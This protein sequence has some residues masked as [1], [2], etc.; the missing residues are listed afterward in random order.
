VA[1]PRTD[2]FVLVTAALFRAA[3]PQ[4]AASVHGDRRRTVRLAGLRGCRAWRC[5]AAAHGACLSCHAGHRTPRR[6]SALAIAGADAVLAAWLRH[7]FTQLLPFDLC[8]ARFA[9]AALGGPDV[10]VATTVAVLGEHRD[11]ILTLAS[12][13]GPEAAEWVWGLTYFDVV[14]SDLIARVCMLDMHHR[15]RVEQSY[16]PLLSVDTRHIWAQQRKDVDRGIMTGI[17]PHRQLPRHQNMSK[18]SGLFTARAQT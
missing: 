9:L 15:H 2:S 18:H 16:S 5:A 7:S 8:C 3:P 4:A 17:W 12:E 14:L 6:G 11:A 1:L 10:L 13:G